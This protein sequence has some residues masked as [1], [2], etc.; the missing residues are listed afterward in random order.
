MSTFSRILIPSTA[1]SDTVSSDP[2]VSTPPLTQGQIIINVSARTSGSITPSIEGYDPASQTWYAILTG[3]SIS[4]VSQTV[5][6]VGNAFPVTTNISVSDIL[7]EKWRVTLTKTGSISMTVSVGAN[8][9][10]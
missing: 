9:A 10:P 5:L 7:P 8:L 3:A 4:S 1:I 6:K 2:V